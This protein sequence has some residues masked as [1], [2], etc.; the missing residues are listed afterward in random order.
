[1]AL[2][3]DIL[4][5]AASLE[6]LLPAWDE[7]ADASGNPVSSGL[8]MLAHARTHPV[9]PRVAVVR[10]GAEVV[11]VLPFGVDA[12]RPGL[13]RLRLLAADA[14]SGAEPLAA[15]GRAADV[16]E[17]AVPALAAA[18]PVIDVVA[19]E[20]VPGDS[21]W[22]ELLAAHWPRATP[23]MLVREDEVPE[24]LVSLD[25]GSFEAWQAAKSS[26]FRAK[27]RRARRRLGDRGAQVRMTSGPD[28]LERDLAAFA[29][30]HHARWQDRGGSGVVTPAV[31]RMLREAGPALL[32]GGR[33]ELWSL[34]TGD[35]IVCSQLWLRAGGGIT[36]WLG[37]LDEAWAK[38]EVTLVT[39]A[40]VVEDAFARR[41]HRV[42]L[43]A[44]DQHYKM[45]FAG[46]ADTLRWWQLP[47]PG[48]RL[49]LV[50]AHLGAGRL[51]RAAGER[52]DDEQKQRVRRVLAAGRAGRRRERTHA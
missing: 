8:W 18:R 25:A 23:R 31:E 17:A 21:P 44:G 47:V 42:S 43:G 5:D 46:G 11:G 2:R 41:L 28:E 15:P 36:F 50:L 19:L 38:E 52:L 22:P 26:H 48:P 16:A 3:T 1:V 39:L 6:P 37:G 32:A 27:L 40:A 12:G 24:P 13:R 34:D 33:L 10:E 14:S 7:L 29:R 49:G 35:D 9:L 45:R 30:L 4:D 51:R 20:G